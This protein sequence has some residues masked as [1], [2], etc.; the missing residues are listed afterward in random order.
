MRRSLTTITSGSWRNCF[1]VLVVPFVV[2]HLAWVTPVVEWSCLCPENQPNHR[3]CCNCPKCVKNRGGFKS[4]CHQRWENAERGPLAQ[5]VSIGGLISSTSNAIDADRPHTHSELSVCQCDSHIKKISLDFNPCI[6]Q[7][8]T[9]CLYPVPV[10]RMI[11]TDDW[12]P[13]EAI[14]CQPD[15][16]G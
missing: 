14:P 11:L 15:S 8:K 16:P 10:A 12:R 4:F 7:V 6:P 13:P 1:A 3:C 2:L 9:C 5:A